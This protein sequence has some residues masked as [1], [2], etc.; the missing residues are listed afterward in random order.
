M[1]RRWLRR[2][3]AEVLDEVERDKRLPVEVRRLAVYPGDVLVLSTQCVFT[4]P[5]Q[6]WLRE[7]IKE[8]FPMARVLI[9]DGGMDLTVC[10]E[11][12]KAS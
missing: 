9:L 12:R 3:L 11:E 10:G 7:R 5:A 1:I 8:Q 4:Q 2:L 6:V